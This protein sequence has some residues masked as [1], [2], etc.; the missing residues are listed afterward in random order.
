[1][2]KRIKQYFFIALII[3]T[4]YFSLSRHII[5][6]GKDF[7]LLEKQDLT[8][9]YTFFSIQEK[10]AEKI[11]KIDPLRRAGIGSI[12]VNLDLISDEERYELEQYFEYE[13]Y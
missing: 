5:F 10:P 4:V 12:L 7:Y 8:L 9:E 2:L 1:M 3:G 13:S 6:Y 11:L